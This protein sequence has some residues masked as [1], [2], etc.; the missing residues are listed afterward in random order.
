M[1]KFLLFL[2]LYAAPLFSQWSEQNS[3]ISF[4]IFSLSAVD[5]NIVWASTSFSNVL[6]TT[7]GGTSWENVGA[8][9]PEPNGFQPCIFGIDANTAIFSCYDGYPVINAYVYKTTNAG[10]N[11][12]LVFTQGDNAYI[13]GIWIKTNNEGFMVGWPVGGRWSLWKTNNAGINWDST[14]LY[15]P[16]TDPAAWSYENSLFY[17]G[18]QV[19]FGARNKGIYYSSNNGISW[20]LQELAW[21]GYAYP[22]AIWFENSSHGYSSADRNIIRTESSG[23]NWTITPNSSGTEIIK[24]IT[25]TGNYW[26]F[27]RFLSN[28]IYY[29]SNDGDTWIIQYTA[30]T[31]SG[32]N[33]ITKGRN[34]GSKLW[35]ARIDGGI[36][37]Y[38]GEVGIKTVNNNI[39]ERFFLYQN[40][41]NPFNPTTKIRF[42]LPPLSSPLPMTGSST[43]EGGDRGVVLKIYDVLGK[44]VATLVNEQLSQGTYEVEWNASDYPSG[45]YFYKL[46]AGSFAETK[47]MILIK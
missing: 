34:G 10:I 26:W 31:N 41:P 14:G 46:R 25:G 42:A 45:I 2:L 47:K 9:I 7:N 11:W 33:H 36:S 20:T 4:T 19:W 37:V 21:T 22:S 6:R 23:M 43:S 17:L 18:S 15:I 27:V 13:S 5:D 3:G 35:A 28:K 16:E 1:K 29:T 24:G 44:E 39:P 30:P 8:N 12:T 32:Y 40:Y 38:T